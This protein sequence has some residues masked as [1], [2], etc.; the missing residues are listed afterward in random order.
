MF[1]T[2]CSI[3]R[4]FQNTEVTGT[5]KE[6]FEHMSFGKD[7]FIG[8]R[9]FDAIHIE[10]K[11]DSEEM[12]GELSLYIHLTVSE[13][14]G[15]YDYQKCLVYEAFRITRYSKLPYIIA[16]SA[17]QPRRCRRQLVTRQRKAYR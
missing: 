15:S 12:T 9:F 3:E 13:V 2:Q 1:S 8:L 14:L 11:S 7:N 17:T 4:C 6:R 10:T 16:E 5:L